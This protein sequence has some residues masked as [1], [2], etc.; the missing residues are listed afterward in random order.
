[1]AVLW[2]IFEV[3]IVIFYSELPEIQRQIQGDYLKAQV[4]DSYHRSHVSSML[5]A[6]TPT[7]ALADSEEIPSMDAFSSTSNDTL[8][9]LVKV[10]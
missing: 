4:D 10:L 7:S 2:I 9:S 1:M 3:L 6:A 8:E 5:D